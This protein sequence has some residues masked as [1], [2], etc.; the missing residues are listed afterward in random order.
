LTIFFEFELY[1]DTDVA[2]L[3]DFLQF[4]IYC[5]LSTC[6]TSACLAG[7]TMD[8]LAY[9]TLPQIDLRVLLEVSLNQII[10]LLTGRVTVSWNACTASTFVFL[11]ARRIEVMFD[12]LEVSLLEPAGVTTLGI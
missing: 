1:V 6:E 3:E 4:L 10:G 5:D 12:K 8:S 7:G 9:V 11:L 2:M